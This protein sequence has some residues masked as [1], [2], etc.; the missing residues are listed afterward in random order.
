MPEDQVLHVNLEA[1]QELDNRLRE[2]EISHSSLATT[3]VSMNA[4][5]TEMKAMFQKFMMDSSEIAGR[6][7]TINR[8]EKQTNEMASKHDELFNRFVILEYTCKT[9]T[10]NKVN[11]HI[12]DIGD[13]VNK[14]ESTLT[15]LKG[16]KSKLS[17]FWS[18]VAQT[19]VT[20]VI[21]YTLYLIATHM[22]PNVNP[23]I[24]TPE[25][26]D[27]KRGAITLVQEA[28]AQPFK[29]FSVNKR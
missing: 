8:L 28:Q 14:I 11:D 27:D 15:E 29:N 17:G 20:A 3:I 9:C 26:K 22:Q 13:K 18:N 21:M 4:N 25:L 24:N 12:K 23:M 2:I 5:I 6:I 7:E 1:H 16:S 10:I 19:I